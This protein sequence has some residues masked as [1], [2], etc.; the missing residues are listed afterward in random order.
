MK[1]G[2]VFIFLAVAFS[3]LVGGILYVS[4]QKN[5]QEPPCFEM[6][7]RAGT[8]GFINEM[9]YHAKEGHTFYYKGLRNIPRMDGGI[10][11]YRDNGKE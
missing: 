10:T 4:I 6:G 9:F 8:E 11:I 7:R 2:S 3:L 1:I 5:Y